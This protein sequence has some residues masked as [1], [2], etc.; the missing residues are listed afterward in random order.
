MLSL[1][2]TSR[3]AEGLVSATYRWAEQDRVLQPHCF[4][5]MMIALLIHKIQDLEKAQNISHSKEN[6]L[7][8]CRMIRLTERNYN[9]FNCKLNHIYVFY[10]VDYIN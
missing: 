3:R 2:P 8:R 7:L 9:N 1:S 10:V 4:D 6:N 5:E